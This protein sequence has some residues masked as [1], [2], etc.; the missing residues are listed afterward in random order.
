MRLIITTLL[1]TCLSTALTALKI[2]NIDYNSGRFR[3][4]SRCNAGPFNSNSHKFDQVVNVPWDQFEQVTNLKI[5]L[6]KINFY[7]RQI[8]IVGNQ[9][10]TFQ[11]FFVTINSTNVYNANTRGNA[12][13]KKALSP[14]TL[15]HQNQNKLNA[16]GKLL[17]KGAKVKNNA[18]NKSGYST[19]N[20]KLMKQVK[21]QKTT[22]TI[23]H[24]GNEKNNFEYAD[25][26]WSSSIHDCDSVA[27]GVKIKFQIFVAKELS[28]KNQGRDNVWYYTELG[29]NKANEREG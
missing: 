14:T 10:T 28:G 9:E 5:K 19:Y 6:A 2:N 26:I 12:Y 4:F 7:K 22:D 18:N 21:C 29:C 15:N 13:S 25:I 8:T 24:R 11:G 3:D 23:R 20:N 16:I 17:P 27:S 1:A